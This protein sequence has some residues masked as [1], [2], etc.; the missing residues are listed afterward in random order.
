MNGPLWKQKKIIIVDDSKS[1][2]ADLKAKF[3]EIHLDV[4]A[5]ASN[6][7]EALELIQQRRPD[8]VSLD[9]IMPE[10]NGFEVFHF[11]Q[12]HQQDVKCFF[13][14]CLSLEEKVKELCERKYQAE[15][16]FAKPLDPKLLVEWLGTLR[17]PVK[18][19]PLKIAS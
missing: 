14:S 2:R 8:F 3:S 6:G 7:I 1:V 16:F 4:I 5:E 18:R 10:M 17:E 19:S 15:G 13:V 12:S 9:I 11:V